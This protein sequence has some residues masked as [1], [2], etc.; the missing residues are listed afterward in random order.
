MALFG[1]MPLSIQGWGVSWPPL[2]LDICEHSRIHL[3]SR[4]KV[5]HSFKWQGEWT[6]IE[7]SVI[8]GWFSLKFC[9]KFSSLWTSSHSKWVSG[10]KLGRITN[11]QLSRSYH[12]FYHKHQ[13]SSWLQAPGTWQAAKY[14]HNPHPFFLA[15]LCIMWF[16]G[17][18]P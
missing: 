1:E 6:G 2:A 7:W 8:H 11:S 10:R 3:N 12:F 14:T 4:F 13:E 16:P 5:S 15:A 9:L 18:D 17:F